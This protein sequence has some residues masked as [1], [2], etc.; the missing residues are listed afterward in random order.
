MNLTKIKAL[1]KKV[2]REAQKAIEAIY[3][4]YNKE[5]ISLIANEVPK[6]SAL[7]S[8]NGVTT[9]ID[10]EGNESNRSRA[11]G[12]DGGKGNLEKLSLMQYATEFRGYF[13]IPE[14]IKGKKITK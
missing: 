4:K 7:Y 3:K 1:N 2:E 11:W 8:W 5:M 13:E 12:F 10:N 9:I 14:E 6:G